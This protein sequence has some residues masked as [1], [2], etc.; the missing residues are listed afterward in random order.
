MLTV[1]YPFFVSMLVS[2]W[3]DVIIF[4][5]NTVFIT[6]LYAKLHCFIYT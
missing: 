5:V 3:Q 4:I 6:T 1:Y 2:V